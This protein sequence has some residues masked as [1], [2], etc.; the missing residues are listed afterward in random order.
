VA[1]ALH[2]TV[3]CT[4][5]QRQA[6]LVDA[7]IA[8]QAVCALDYGDLPPKSAADIC[9][10]SEGVVTAAKVAHAMNLLAKRQ[11]SEM[12]PAPLDVDASD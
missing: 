6:V 8:Q 12:R 3:A 7:A 5:A 1:G 11:A 10:V 4:A 2:S 9:L